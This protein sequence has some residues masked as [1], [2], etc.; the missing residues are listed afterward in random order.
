MYCNPSMVCNHRP[1]LNQRVLKT[2][3]PTYAEARYTTAL[4][5]RARI[6]TLVSHEVPREACNH[7]YSSTG[8]LAVRTNVHIEIRIYLQKNKD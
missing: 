6:T 4:G 5:H 2:D 3:C 8:S 1:E 7:A